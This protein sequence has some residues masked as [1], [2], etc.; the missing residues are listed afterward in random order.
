MRKTGQ[1]WKRGRLKRMKINPSMN[2]S[3]MLLT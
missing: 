2:W 1:I 3:I